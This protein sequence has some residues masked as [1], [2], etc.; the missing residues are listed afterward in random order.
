MC[1]PQPGQ[2]PRRTAYETSGT[3][4]YQASSLPQ[5]IQA[6]AGLTSDRFSGTRAA[7]TFR[8]EPKASPGASARAARL[9]RLL[10]ARRDYFV[11]VNASMLAPVFGG[12]GAPVGMFVISGSGLNEA[13]LKVASKPP[14]LIGPSIVT[15]F[16]TNVMI[17][18]GSVHSEPW[19]VWELFVNVTDVVFCASATSVSIEWLLLAPCQLVKSQGVVAVAQSWVAFPLKV[20]VPAASITPVPV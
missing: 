7:T 18:D 3:L 6:D 9:I 2:R 11:M 16:F 1:S 17:D 8:N 12:S 15:P 10:S 13:L 5:L 4:S 14:M 19:K 20:I